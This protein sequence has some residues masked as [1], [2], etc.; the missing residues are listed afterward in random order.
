MIGF[1][2]NGQEAGA[3]GFNETTTSVCP[4]CLRALPARLTED[5]AGD[6]YLERSCPE[7]GD[8]RELVWEGFADLGQWKD[9]G[10][11]TTDEATISLPPN[12]CP[13]GCET[14]TSHLTRPC[15]VLLEVTQRCDLGCPVCFA[16]TGGVGAGDEPTL[17]EVTSW[18]D[19]ILARAGHANIQLSGGEPT[20]RDDLP[21]IITLGRERGFSFF[22]INTNGLRLATE[23]G[24]ARTLKDAGASC[25]FLQFDGVTDDAYRTLRGRPLLTEKR[26]AIEACEQAGLPVVLVPTVALGVNDDQLGDIVHFA[27]R[28]A[29]TV[30][31]IH[32]QPLARF[33]RVDATL[34]GGRLTIPGVLAA[35]DYQTGGMVSIDH[36]QGGSAE[37]PDCSFSASY[38]IGPGGAL[39]HLPASHPLC[40]GPA[41][42]P[43]RVQRARTANSLRWGTDLASLDVP[44]EEGSLDA[45]LQESRRNA[46]SIT[47]MAFMDA[48]TLDLVR[49][50]RCYLFIV[51]RRGALV[52]FCAYNLTSRDG[53][54]LYR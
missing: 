13:G 41:T 18:Y 10:G 22:Q 49:L 54:S 53:C 7:H 3:V 5:A 20:L 51:S 35:L 30:R 19:T 28:H 40:C 25:V 27:M 15:C 50:R 45:F 39:T 12:A 52:P 43:D 9:H 47:G 48:D 4:V 23:S 36:F 29:P 6:V 8:F 46:F 38:R 31:G 1:V 11:I 42:E 33:G 17:E 32:I 16:Q 24:Y 34:P 37:S 21:Q 2:S 44:A 14:C 26:C